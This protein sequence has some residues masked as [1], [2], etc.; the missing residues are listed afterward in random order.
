MQDFLFWSNIIMTFCMGVLFLRSPRY[1]HLRMIPAFAFVG[2]ALAVVHLLFFLESWHFYL[3]YNIIYAAF[4]LL[5][6]LEVHR[7]ATSRVPRWSLWALAALAVIPFLPIRIDYLSI[8]PFALVDLLI[9]FSI[10]RAF[11]LAHPLF[12]L[13]TAF[14]AWGLVNDLFK[15]V[16]PFEPVATVLGIFDL[17]IGRLFILS[18]IVLAVWQPVTLW[19]YHKL[20]QLL[21]GATMTPVPVAV[22]APAVSHDSNLVHFPRLT[23]AASSMPSRDLIAGMKQDMDQLEPILKSA[24]QMVAISRK[25]FL[26]CDE[27][28]LYLDVDAASAERFI[29][30]KQINRIYLIEGSDYWVVRRLD[31]DFLIEDQTR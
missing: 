19:L 23:Q 26:N 9:A 14:S 12:Q 10:H 3:Y 18:M 13:M 6:F 7:D 11:N 28:A 8:I 22:S 31:I 24:A 21:F 16:V 27:L 15:V 17:T 4:Y 1:S 20:H 29:E 5:A 2:S 30:N 25:P